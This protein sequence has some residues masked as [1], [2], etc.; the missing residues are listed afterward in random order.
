MSSCGSEIAGRS[1]WRGPGEAAA[2]VSL[3]PSICHGP[4]AAFGQQGQQLGEK[5]GSGAVESKDKSPSHE[6]RQLQSSL[7]SIL[8]EE[9][10][11][12][13]G[14]PKGLLNPA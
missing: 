7:L 11:R 12:Y 5:P 8:T 4:Q 3:Q 1:S 2:S 10:I 13:N 14:S 9:S 6:N